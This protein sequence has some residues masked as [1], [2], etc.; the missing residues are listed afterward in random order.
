MPEPTT[1]AEVA[2]ELG[3]IAL[4]TLW[5]TGGDPRRDELFHV[6]ALK[7]EGD[8]W[9]RFEL[10]VAPR[11][12]T[13]EG[14]DEPDAKARATRRMQREF[15]VTAT[16]LEG[17]PS[18]DEAWAALLAFL[19]DGPL[20]VPRRAEFEAWARALDPG[21]NPFARSYAGAAQLLALDEFHGLFL[22]GARP[23]AEP[24]D[25]DALLAAFA[26]TLRDL[27]ELPE[28]VLALAARG[29]ARVAAGLSAD[30]SETTAAGAMILAL[31]LVEYPSAWAHHSG[32]LFDQALVDGLF[33]RSLEA[34]DDPEAAL[35]KA[36]PRW[37][38]PFARLEEDPPKPPVHEG[39]GPL[40][41]EDLAR[42]DDIF[43]THLPARFAEAGAKPA[44]PIVREGQRELANQ[45]ARLFGRGELLLSHA[46]TGTGKTLAYLVPLTL[47]ALRR[48]LRCGVAT[49]TR[50]LQDQAFERDVPLCLS[51]LKEAGVAGEPRIVRLKGRNNYLCWRALRRAR[52]E[53]E[54]G[55]VAPGVDRERAPELFAWTA[56]L[57][58]AAV[59]PDGD[60]D[61]F[62]RDLCLPLAKEDLW[63]VARQRILR[64]VRAETGCCSGG[65][66]RSTCGSEIARRRAERAHVVI[67]NHSF[68]LARQEF[69]R[70]VVFDEC[71][72]L[73]DQARGAWSH[74]LSTAR[75]QRE[76]NELYRERS[77]KGPLGELL[78]AAPPG[79]LIERIAHGAIDRQRGV[80]LGL[81]HLETELT[82]YNA[83]RREEEGRRDPRDRHGVFREFIER[84]P[85]QGLVNVQRD[86]VA[87]LARL[88]AAL[89]DL[90][91]HLDEL[92][93]KRRE[94][95]RGALSIRRLALYECNESLAAWIPDDEKRADLT[96][97]FDPNVFYDVTEDESP[98]GRGRSRQAGHRQGSSRLMAQV[99][100]PQEDLGMRYFP[101]LE[102]AILL[103]AT[104]WIKGGF[105][106]SASYLGLTRCAEPAP[107]EAREGR[108]HKT[109]K[110]PE[111][112]DYG[113]VLVAVPRD[114]PAVRERD[115]YLRYVTRFLAHLGERT[116]GRILCL[117]TNGRD[118]AEVGRG[119]TE[120][121]AGTEVPVFWQGMGIAKEELAERFR[122]RTDS[123]LLGLDTFW[124]GADFPG[125]TLEYLVIA[126]LPY[127]VPDD[128]HFAQEASMGSREQRR[129]VYMP[130]SLARFRQGFGRLM[131]RESDRGCV[132]LLDKR[133][134]EPRHR[135]FLT[136]LPIAGPLTVTK[137]ATGLG[138]E[139][140]EDPA[141]LARL[142][143]GD[144]DHILREAF[145]HMGMLPDIERRGL[146]Q[147]FHE[148]SP[149]VPA[150]ES[151]EDP[152]FFPSGEPDAIDQVSPFDQHQAPPAAPARPKRSSG[153]DPHEPPTFFM[154]TEE[155]PF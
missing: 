111:V 38:L 136:E 33:S 47:W 1:T 37:H 17:A 146:A 151:E 124:Y 49:F 112:F 125:E 120:A 96:P 128:Y 147:Q 150:A 152:P 113:R 106:A 11:S 84:G 118:L 64:S 62:P 85:S 130:R 67:A 77:G 144:T 36:K 53:E 66:D 102:S 97:R 75:L 5:A 100:L 74:V 30:A 104:T 3:G 91:D 80:H 83:W 119:L 121:M 139:A 140:P 131:R 109:L 94:V 93:S 86:L 129:R 145:A 27:G 19:G 63:L 14:L 39:S 143:R 72:H 82:R 40:A 79:S 21:D 18:A 52:P 45:I 2:Q 133:V 34:F 20:L 10:F 126:R 55:S 69:L 127:G 101:E 137:A 123:I 99:L 16:D 142:V 23:P 32:E 71:E 103:S 51:L 90:A 81:E 48:G 4:V 149:S 44:K 29:L 78:G 76:L 107:D 87:D 46:P 114:A 35:K 141:R 116:R 8:T 58:F 154:P 110:I 105:E 61:A 132:F 117:F 92:P 122:A 22:P 25:P 15:G 95:L 26:G 98:L 41:P 57:L 43:G 56:A 73:H 115:N 6:A 24:R 88:D 42:I 134:I 7:R 89:S 135:S 153:P 59:S 28:P 54:S 155:P 108:A 12:R 50:A 148:P 65:H 68:V 9:R 60:L 31:T 70:H 138:D 13:G